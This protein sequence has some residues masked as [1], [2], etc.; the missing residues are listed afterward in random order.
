MYYNIYV[1]SN[2]GLIQTDGFDTNYDSLIRGRNSTA[3]SDS[4]TTNDIIVHITY[5]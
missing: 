4:I 5:N 1:Y 3:R 2:N